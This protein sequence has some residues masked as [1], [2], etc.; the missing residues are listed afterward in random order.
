MFHQVEVIS[1]NTPVTTRGGGGDLFEYGFVIR[2]LKAVTLRL[3]RRLRSPTT[4]PTC[5]LCS[6]G[7][8]RRW[9]SS[10]ACQLGC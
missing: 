3:E 7:N 4:L 10:H 8:V 2:L 6:S 5:T 9:D 1:C